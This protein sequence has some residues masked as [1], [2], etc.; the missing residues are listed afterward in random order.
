MGRQKLGCMEKGADE[1]FFNF[2]NNFCSTTIYHIVRGSARFCA[3]PCAV[4]HGSVRGSARFR[5][6]FCTVPSAV[7]QQYKDAILMDAVLVD[8]PEV[9]E[10]VTVLYGGH[11]HREAPG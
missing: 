6:R 3:A 8:S 2:I 5:A 4:L 1:G 9:P 11:R 10:R 7:P